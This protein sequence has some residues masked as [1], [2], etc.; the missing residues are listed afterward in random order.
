M[1]LIVLIFFFWSQFIYLL[2]YT[3]LEYTTTCNYYFTAYKLTLHNII[4]K[5]LRTIIQNALYHMIYYYVYL[6][7]KSNIILNNLLY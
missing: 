3:I 2:H 1:C 5:P 6:V 7:Y 4:H